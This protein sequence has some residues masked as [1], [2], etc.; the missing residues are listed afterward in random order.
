MMGWD[1]RFRKSGLID[2][3]MIYALAGGSHLGGDKLSSSA[4]FFTRVHVWH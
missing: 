1:D 3:I 2:Q 4:Y